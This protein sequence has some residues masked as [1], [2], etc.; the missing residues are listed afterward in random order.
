[1]SKIKINKQDGQNNKEHEKQI[2]VSKDFSL[3]KKE[4]GWVDRNR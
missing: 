3:D 4:I 1:M 2:C